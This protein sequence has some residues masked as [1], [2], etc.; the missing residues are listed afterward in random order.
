MRNVETYF[1]GLYN[2]LKDDKNKD[3]HDKILTPL[4]EA[5]FNIKSSAIAIHVCFDVDE[6]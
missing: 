2:E 6:F 4:N 1:E 5:I 3:E